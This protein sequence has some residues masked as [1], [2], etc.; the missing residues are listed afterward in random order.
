MSLSSLGNI[1]RIFQEH[2]S[3]LSCFVWGLILVGCTRCLKS[4]WLCQWSNW[5]K[6]MISIWVKCFPGV[7][8]FLPASSESRF[9]C[10]L[11]RNTGTTLAKYEIIQCI[12]HVPSV[13]LGFITFTFYNTRMLYAYILRLWIILRVFNI[14]SNIPKMRPCT[15]F[16][17]LRGDLS[18]LRRWLSSS[19][20]TCFWKAHT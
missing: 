13:V 12:F 20:D 11:R 6:W 18:P 4:H 5:R 14:C 10:G 15:W 17:L 19:T 1:W 7:K 16:M 2:N 9:R 8:T 3:A